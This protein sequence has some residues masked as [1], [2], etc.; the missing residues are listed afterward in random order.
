M[1]QDEGKTELSLRERRQVLGIAFGFLLVLG[2]VAWIMIYNAAPSILLEGISREFRAGRIRRG[3]GI[4]VALVFMVTWLPVVLVLS[5]IGIIQGVRR[6]RTR[7][8]KWILLAMNKG[9]EKASGAEI[10]SSCD[11]GI[12][13]GS[14]ETSKT[15]CSHRE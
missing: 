15:D 12:E 1:E 13:H 11:N 10:E 7:L 5:V 9:A 3:L 2:F 4:C 14:V 8:T 6:R